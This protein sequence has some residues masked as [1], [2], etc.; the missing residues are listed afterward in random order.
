MT[1]DGEAVEEKP[2]AVDAIE[3]SR[4]RIGGVMVEDLVFMRGE[5]DARGE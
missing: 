2:L 4:S 1:L 3:R 5:G